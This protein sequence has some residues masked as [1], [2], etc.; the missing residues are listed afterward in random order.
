M[1]IYM[2]R[3][4]IFVSVNVNGYTSVCYF[5]QLEMDKGEIQQ[6]LKCQK[7][8]LKYD[9]QCVHHKKICSLLMDNSTLTM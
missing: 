6:S 7:E 3:H 4:V 8:K 1:C 5:C 9:R 2:Y